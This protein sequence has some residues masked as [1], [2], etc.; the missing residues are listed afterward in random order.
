MQKPRYRIYDVARRAWLSGLVTMRTDDGGTIAIGMC[1][2]V[3]P[4]G[5]L[6][7]PGAKS[8]RAALATLDRGDYQIQNAKGVALK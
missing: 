7:Y 6:L 1:W 2:T 5:A 8:A 3:D 4:E